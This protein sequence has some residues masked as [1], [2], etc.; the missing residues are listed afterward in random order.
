MLSDIHGN[1]DGLK[2]VLEHAGKW[3]YVWVLG[4]LVDYGPEPHIVVDMI[5]DLEPDAIVRGNHDNAVA[6]NVDCRCSPKTH[7]LSVYTR[8]MISYNLLS[9]EQVK[10]LKTLPLTQKVIVDHVRYY[11]VHGSPLNPLYGYLKPDMSRE[12]LLHYLK[13]SSFDTKP[14]DTDYLI[15]GHT[16]LAF[17]LKADEVTV[18]NPGSVGQPRDGVAKASYMVI[19]TDEN[20]IIYH[21]INYDIDSVLKKLENLGIEEKYF[22]QLKKILYT[23]KI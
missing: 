1:A 15:V 20:R 21:R 9:K 13:K 17:M 5:R 6:F 2:K 22:K 19:D 16:H 7:D 4:D 18:V 10:W 3:D 12:K 23:A 11:L 8:Y 14:V